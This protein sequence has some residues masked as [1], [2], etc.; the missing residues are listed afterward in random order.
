MNTNERIQELK[1]EAAAISELVNHSGKR[2]PKLMDR[3]HEIR[4]EIDRLEEQEDE[5]KFI[6]YLDRVEIVS[7][8]W[9][10]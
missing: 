3:I 6:A 8:P 5:S 10:Y 9:T 4:Q 7:G 1:S 2:D